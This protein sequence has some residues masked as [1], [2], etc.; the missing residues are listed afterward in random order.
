MAQGERII[1]VKDL[2]H[3]FSDLKLS[4][5]NFDINKNEHF[6]IS[7][8][9]GKGK[10]TLLHLLSGLLTVKEGSISILGT[11]LENQSQ[12]ELDAFRGKH[13]GI[14]FQHPKF[15][16]AISVMENLLMAQL[17]GKVSQNKERCLSLLSDLGIESKARK[18]PSILSGGERQRLALARA[19]SCGPEILFADEPT[20][21]LDDN[22]AEK[23]YNLLLKEANENNAVLGVVSHDYRLRNKFEKRIEL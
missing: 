2:V 4:Y 12:S 23:V 22:N 3:H 5:P 11:L 1:Q 10:S 20:S 8:N 16:N 18:S 14:V 15:V 6:L 21:G 7:G 13:V 9:S 19:L 17:F